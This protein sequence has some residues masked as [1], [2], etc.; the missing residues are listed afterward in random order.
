MKGNNSGC[1]RHK[2]V[3]ASI[4]GA[5][6]TSAMCVSRSL[7]LNLAGFSVYI[8]ALSVNPW[9]LT[10]LTRTVNTSHLCKNKMKIFSAK[11]KS[12]RHWN[13]WINLMPRTW[14]RWRG[15]KAFSAVQWCLNRESVGDGYCSP[16]R[17]PR[18][19]L[20]KSFGKQKESWRK[21]IKS[22]WDDNKHHLTQLSLQFSATLSLTS[23]EFRSANL[24]RMWKKTRNG[25]WDESSNILT[26][27]LTLRSL[28]RNF[29]NATDWASFKA[30]KVH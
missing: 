4:F 28:W 20:R 21:C 22:L 17:I 13:S 30:M 11:G 6:Y 24:C 3:C 10:K 14:C 23:S 15:L 7:T 18:Q 2:C 12:F 8:S 27:L 19:V 25:L 26:T 5:K 1:R 9:T 16:F 29:D